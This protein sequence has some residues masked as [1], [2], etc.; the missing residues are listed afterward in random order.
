MS[1]RLGLP[2][3]Y[4]KS[5][6]WEQI[7]AQLPELVGTMVLLSQQTE[8]DINGQSNIANSPSNNVRALIAQTLQQTSLQKKSELQRELS[9]VVSPAGL[10][11]KIFLQSDLDLGPW[12]SHLM[13]EFEGFKEDKKPITKN[14]LSKKIVVDYLK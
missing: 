9:M 14:D 6:T 3:G 13:D 10:K 11:V 1:G 4:T 5:F 12:I 7:Q 8:K 2:G